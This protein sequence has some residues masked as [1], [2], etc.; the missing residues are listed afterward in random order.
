MDATNTCVP[1]CP[2]IREG[3]NRCRGSESIPKPSAKAETAAAD[4]YPKTLLSPQHELIRRIDAWRRRAAVGSIQLRKPE[5]RVPE[6]IHYVRFVPW[7][8]KRYVG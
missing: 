5:Q 3:G 2:K 7:P 6:D 8:M 4:E 1:M